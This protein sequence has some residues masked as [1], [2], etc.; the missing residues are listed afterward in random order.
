MPVMDKTVRRNAPLIMSAFGSAH[1][2]AAG[3]TM[4]HCPIIEDARDCI[5]TMRGDLQLRRI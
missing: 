2:G 1:R 3:D 5:V 4:N